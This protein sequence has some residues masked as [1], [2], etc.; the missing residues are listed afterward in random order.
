[1]GLAFLLIA[2]KANA[3]VYYVRTDGGPGGATST[4]CNGQT[5]AAFTGANGPGCAFN[6]PNWPL[7]SNGQPT[8]YKI[9]GGDTLVIAP[10]SYKMGCQND[11]NCVEATLNYT[12]TSQCY[13]AWTY[14]CGDSQPPSGSLGNETKIYG[15][16]ITGCGTNPKPE[17]WMV[18]RL[19]G[20]F[21]LSGISYVEFKDIEITDHWGADG[22]CSHGVPVQPCGRSAFNA[23]GGWHHLTFT[24]MDLHGG[25]SGGFSKFGGSGVGSADVAWVLTDTNI[26]GFKHAGIDMDS[27]GNN[28][29]CGIQGTV[30]FTGV[31]MRWNGCSEAYPVVWGEDGV[32]GKVGRLPT[33]QSCREGNNGGYGDMIGTSN[34]GG[35]W[36]FIDCNLSH[37]SSDAIDL[38]YCNTD[39]GGCDVIVKRSLLEGNN[40]QA[41]KAQ[42]PYVEDSVI[43]GNCAF[44]SDLV[45][46]IDYTAPNFGPCRAT[47]TPFSVQFRDTTTAKFY[48]N[49]IIGGGDVLWGVNGTICNMEVKNNII[50]GGYDYHGGGDLIGMYYTQS[51]GNWADL[52]IVTD[53]NICTSD[54]K[55]GYTQCGGTN[56]QNLVDPSTIFTGT[57]EQ[58]DGTYGSGFYGGAYYFGE[59][60]L[61]DTTTARD[62]ADETVSGTDVYDYNTYNRG[63]SW[64]LGGLEHGTTESPTGPICG[65]NTT[66]GAEVCDGTD[67]NG[68]DCT[69]VPGSIWD[70]GTLGCL[71]NC[72]NYNTSACTITLCGNG[73]IDTGEDCD[74]LGPLLGG[75]TC[76]S[77]G[78]STDP[79][80]ANLACTVNTCLFDVSGCAP[81]ACQDG[82]VEGAEDCDDGNA[83]EGDNCS[84]ICQ[85]ENPNYE[86][87]L[88]YTETDPNSRLSI[89]TH[90]VSTANL[91]RNEGANIKIDL[92]A[93]N[94][95]DFVYDY[96]LDQ[97]SCTDS[98]QASVIYDSGSEAYQTDTSS[99]TFSHTIGAGS[100]GLLVVGITREVGASKN[101]SSVTYGGTPLTRAGG[102]TTTSVLNKV[103]VYYLLAPTTGTANV[104]ITYTGTVYSTVATADSWFNIIQQAPEVVSNSVDT[105]NSFVTLSSDSLAISS[106]VAAISTATLTTTD[107]E[108]HNLANP[109]GHKMGLSSKIIPIAGS[110]SM[111]W[112]VSTGN[113]ATTVVVFASINIGGDNPAVQGILS[114]ASA[115]YADIKTQETAGDG[116]FVY[117]TC[118]SSA[119]E[120]I[121]N[122]ESPDVST[123]PDTYTDANYNI[124]RYGKLTRSGTNLTNSIYSDPNRTLLL[125]T[126]TVTT[127]A[128]TH[129]YLMVAPS[130]ND[131]VT[132]TAFSGSVQNLD[133][134]GDG[135]PVPATKSFEIDGQTLT[136][137]SMP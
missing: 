78:Y 19:G 45:S 52:N 7:P 82:Y 129:R 61:N 103:D 89:E 22:E 114:V 12:S 83:T 67:L 116:L 39:Y 59:L 126:Q 108:R 102:T 125:D 117:L 31:N 32:G 42:S 93:G 80:D 86:L 64:D 11:S 95:G 134:T 46:D 30:D 25:T 88:T 121:W 131:S 9:S 47:G 5:N 18:G 35:T 60:Y 120:N 137:S 79:V 13:S 57:L 37:N 84:S 63:A 105:N 76:A 92:G 75:A 62:T 112:S 73:S 58:G 38:L 1:M 53:N 124:V 4:T 77:L 133:L 130:Y 104:V 119:A 101:I 27:C 118:R 33:P 36:T 41:I 122:L 6:H 81:V 26:D 70:G 16:S 109:G 8:T 23:Y 136:G 69:D 65:D 51:C 66:E 24:G 71:S 48:N 91:T 110:S 72:T 115:S 113:Y 40:G 3:T 87:F 127:A 107:T 43:I 99:V 29:T 54:F 123:T 44:F 97:I 135:T 20:M 28:G 14:S 17:L 74:T 55:T 128:T 21:N 94:I 2:G 50:V 132:G 111:N 96:R 15:C 100:N 56:D 68:Y 49:T 85:T 90:E 106:V 10:G 98:T 34:T